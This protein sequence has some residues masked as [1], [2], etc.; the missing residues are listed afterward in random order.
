MSDS[1]VPIVLFD[2]DGVLVDVSGSYR[3]AIQE[4]AAQFLGRPVAPEEVQRYKNQGGFNDDWRLT[5]AIIRDGGLDVPFDDIRSSFDL[6][7]RGETWNGFI[8]QEPPL[9]PRAI[10]RDVQGRSAGM[11]IVTGRPR[12]EAEWTVHRFGWEPFFNVLVAM[13]DQ[14]GRGKPDPYPMRVALTRFVEP[15]V[16]CSTKR[17]VY[18]GDSIDDMR[19]ARAAGLRAIGFVPPYLAAT[20]LEQR[21]FDAGA[22][23]VIDTHDRL[24]PALESLFG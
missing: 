3:R 22:D 17:T 24:I 18:I 20:D 23:L 7:Y 11:G 10:L 8:T 13:E 12:A 19:S 9:I 16:D 14:D 5:E 2:M 6:R 21:L 4:T 15:G 1:S